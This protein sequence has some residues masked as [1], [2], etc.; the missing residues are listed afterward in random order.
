MNNETLRSFCLSLPQ[1]TEDIKWGSDLCFCVGKK[2]FCVAG[3]AAEV[4]VC[5]KCAEEDFNVLCERPGIIPA[6]YLGRNKWVLVQKP[7]A[8]NT[9]EWRYFIRMSYDLVTAGLPKKLKMEL[10]LL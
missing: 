1:V 5:F 3:T 6:P 8:L 9:G 2:M 7:S 10:G 4:S